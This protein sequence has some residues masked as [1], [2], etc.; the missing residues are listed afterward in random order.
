MVRIPASFIRKKFRR[1]TGARFYQLLVPNQVLSIKAGQMTLFDLTEQRQLWSFA[2]KSQT[3][4]AA[5]PSASA[6]AGD[7][8]AFYPKPHVIATAN[9]LWILSP[10]RITQ[11]DRHTGNSKQEIPLNPPFFGMAQNDGGITVIS[12]D[13]SGREIIIRI[14]LPGGTIQTEPVESVTVAPAPAGQLI[15]PTVNA[16]EPKARAGERVSLGD[17]FVPAGASVVQ[18]K[19]GLIERKTITHQAMKP[20][21][22]SLLE[23]NLTASQSMEAS[24]Q[25]V[26]DLR[27][28]QPGGVEEE[29]ASRYQVTLRRH[30]ANSA[31]DWTGEVIGSPT[32]FALKTLD[33]LVGVH[34]IDVFDKNN[35]RLWTAEPDLPHRASLFGGFCH[36]SR[37][38]VRGSGRHLVCF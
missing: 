25:V 33:V 12:S 18:M 7:N 2:L 6:E 38:A 3:S 17:R 20:Q 1:A 31:P 27:R 9:D 4:P 15:A 19:T 23:D 30:P 14:A 22:K 13:E 35:R 8:P 29:D 24:E 36:G 16:V 11:Y 34:S 10:G 5:L 28:E 26:N 32:F 37:S 21:K